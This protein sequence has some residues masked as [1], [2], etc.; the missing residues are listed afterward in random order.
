VD[1]PRLE[2]GERVE[3]FLPRRQRRQRFGRMVREDAAR[4]RQAAPPPVP[5]DQA[6]A[7][8]GFEQSEVCARRRLSDP[9]RLRSGGDASRPLDL[10]EETEPCRVPEQRERAIG[11][12]DTTYWEVR[13]AR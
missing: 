10:D 5:L 7:G 3:L 11:Q 13:L 8:R 12:D 1:R 6:L 2:A 9:D 4:L